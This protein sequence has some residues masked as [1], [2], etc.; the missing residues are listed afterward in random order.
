MPQD[1]STLIEQAV[2]GGNSLVYFLTPE[3]DRTLSMLREVAARR[4]G[5]EVRTW[6]TLEGLSNSDLGEK[7]RDAVTAIK[8]IEN[9]QYSGFFLF[10]DLHFQ[11]EDPLVIRALREFYH[12]SEGRNAFIFVSSAELVVPASLKKELF[13]IE[14]PPPDEDA[15]LGQVRAS[16]DHSPE[17]QLTEADVTELVLALKGLTSS[18]IGHILRRTLDNPRATKEDMV[19]NIFREKEMIVKKSGYLEYTP[20]RYSIDDI[21]GLDNLKDWLI[22][23]KKVFTKEA[24]DAGVAMPKG[25]L[26]MGVSGCGK[27]LAVK[28]ISSLWNVPIFRLDMN[29]VF[30]GLYGNPEAAFRGALTTV[31]TV[32]PAILWVDEIENSLGMEETGI[33]ISSHIFSAF[34]TWMQEKPPMIFIA[35]TAN[36][37][38]ALPAEIIRKGR[39]DQVFFCDL[40][41][42]SERREIVTIHLGRNGANIEDFDVNYLA[43][44][45]EGWSGA[46]IDTAISSARIEAY[47]EDRP[48]NMDDVSKVCAKIVPLSQ[49]MEEQIKYI[50]S[51][52]FSRAT[53]ASKFGKMK[54]KL[55]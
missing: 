36:K 32:A 25:L 5:C 52:A 23:R 20:P 50:R 54:K 7:G 27:S 3:E 15:I 45:M 41:A 13:L 1:V 46:E 24:L 38:N 47:Y 29:L 18:E 26:M 39:F 31:E 43:I 12:S 9:G 37:I 30:S 42:E 33:T 49:T 16:L 51:W 2:V 6:S 44:M 35:A 17:V 11:L 28:V 10:R 48:F 55:K 22:R 40:P 21:G 53:P 8:A 4:G 14:V 19:S 34:L